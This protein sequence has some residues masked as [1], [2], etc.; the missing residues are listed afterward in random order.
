ME[1][2]TDNKFIQVVK[3]GD[4]CYTRDRF[5][6]VLAYIKNGSNCPYGVTISIFNIELCFIY[7]SNLWQKGLHNYTLRL[8]FIRKLMFN[9][10]KKKNLNFELR[11]IGTIKIYY[12]TYLGQKAE[13]I[14]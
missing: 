7:Y 11:T 6:I 14:F 13:A 8:T 1:F 12:K 9:I 4:Q 2:I 10:H 5:L 3:I